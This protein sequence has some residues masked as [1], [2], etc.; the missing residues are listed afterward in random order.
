MPL[1]SLFEWDCACLILSELCGD[2]II[3]FHRILAWFV[4]LTWERICISTSYDYSWDIRCQVGTQDPMVR[5][6]FGTRQCETT[7]VGIT[8]LVPSPF[9]RARAT[10]PLG[11]FVDDSVLWYTLVEKRW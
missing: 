10:D 9:L 7:F 1:R 5:E 6:G 4:Q 3:I 2:L 11:V 8:P